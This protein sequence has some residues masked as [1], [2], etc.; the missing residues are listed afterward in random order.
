MSS[1]VP[2]RRGNDPGD[3]N[4]C[5]ETLT[6]WRRLAAESFDDLARKQVAACV[7]SISSTTPEWRNAIG[8]DAAAACGL[9]LRLETPSR[10]GL[11]VDL[12]MT[13]LLNT[14]FENAG[15]AAVLS[16]AL[17]RMPLNPRERTRL[18]ASWSVH[19]VCLTGRGR[20][21]RR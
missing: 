13:V 2:R 17:Q 8:G 4:D 21:G 16:N 14:A 7:A 10:I 1:D 12:A 18:A 20:W 6:Y 5:T 11:Q 3:S 9:I 15:A 19:K